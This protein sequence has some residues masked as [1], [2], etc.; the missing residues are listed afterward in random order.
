MIATCLLLLLGPINVHLCEVKSASGPI[1]IVT[2]TGPAHENG[3][4]FVKAE[5]CAA[6]VKRLT[7]RFG[8]TPT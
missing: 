4:G 7:E 6:V 1:C 3:S 8:G 5:P 2:M